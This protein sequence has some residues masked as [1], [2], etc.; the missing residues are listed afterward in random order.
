MSIVTMKRKANSQRN[1]SRGGSFKL[2]NKKSTLSTKGYLSSRLVNPSCNGNGCPP[3]LFNSKSE[4]DKSFNIGEK[5][6]SSYIIDKAY[7]C[8]NNYDNVNG[9]GGGAVGGNIKDCGIVKSII[10]TGALNS[11]QHIRN[12]LGNCVS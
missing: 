9:I 5:T 7:N 12:K 6:Q 10:T 1:I 4:K 3:K 2:N 8:G 11:S